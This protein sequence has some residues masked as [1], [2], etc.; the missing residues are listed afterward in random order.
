MRIRLSLLLLWLGVMV[1]LASAPS[2]DDPSSGLVANAVHVAQYAIFFIILASLI[3][4][5]IPRLPARALVVLAG[6]LAVLTGVAQEW[7]QSFLPHRHG[8]PADLL[9]DAVGVAGG[10]LLWL[11]ADAFR[12]RRL[13]RPVAAG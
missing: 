10:L 9:Y 1:A 2:P 13:Q 3:R 8:D 4:A 11:L 6:S 5:A 12:Q 7:Y